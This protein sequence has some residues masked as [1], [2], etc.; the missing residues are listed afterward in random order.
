M[1]QDKYVFAQLTA[2]LNRGKFNRIVA[3]YGGD[4][5]VKSLTCWNQMLAMMFGQLSKLDSLR[6]LIVVL[7]AHQSK[8]YHL[9][10]GRGVSKSSLARAN[11]DRDC[12]IFEEFA[13]HLISEARRKRVNDIFKLGGRVYAFD[14]TTIDLCLSVFWWA[15]FKTTK[16]GVKL[17]TLF[18]MEAQV[19]AFFLITDAAVHDSRVMGL[20]PYEPDSYY[21]FDRAYTVYSKLFRIDLIDAY[22]VVRAKRNLQFRTIGWKRRLPKN[23]LSDRTVMFTEYKSAHDYP[24]P[25]RLVRFYDEDQRRTFTFMTNATHLSSLEV[26]G[27]YKNRWHIELFFKWIKQHL[28]IKKFW[29]TSE[30]AVKTQIY[31]AICTYCMVAIVHHDLNPPKTLGETLQIIGASLLDKTPL[32]DLLS[33][34]NFQDDKE[35]CDPDGPSLFSYI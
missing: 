6:N 7:E 4:R 9:G 27:L 17:H 28:R 14:S 29:G 18:D 19:P 32:R 30:N 25:L 1:F 33:K 22:F 8:C 11:R 12:R 20:V 31:T 15:K 10:M 34:T 21:V 35:L 16:G 26:A 3:R 5:Y 24:K 23:I 2:S 13:Y